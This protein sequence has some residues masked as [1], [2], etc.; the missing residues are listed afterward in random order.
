MSLESDT[1]DPDQTETE[2]QEND[3]HTNTLALRG[4]QK[5]EVSINK[6]KT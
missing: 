3:Q 6:S 4:I 5:R 1:K 2:N